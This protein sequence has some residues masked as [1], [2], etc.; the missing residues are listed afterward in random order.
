[1]PAFS[2]ACVS[3][4]DASSSP[5]IATSW[6]SNSRSP[7]A[8]RK[9]QTGRM[10]MRIIRA[11]SRVREEELLAPDPVAGDGLLARRGNQP[12]D[13]RAPH[14]RLHV[15]M[16]GGIHEHHAVLVEEAV[17]ALDEHGELAAVAEGKPR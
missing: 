11:L 9:R 8:P 1:M 13:E 12:F 16:P 15:R 10:S 3:L 17:V 6:K 5:R 14:R 7:S 2:A 4:P